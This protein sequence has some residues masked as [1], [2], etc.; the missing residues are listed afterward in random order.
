[1]P[2]RT[3]NSKHIVDT[4]ERLAARIKERFPEASL[5]HVATELIELANRDLRR[6]QRLARP[7]W[8]LSDTRSERM[9]CSVLIANNITAK[10]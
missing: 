1:M 9:A 5:N 3:L 2:F 4:L 10:C 8:F 7:Y 6:T